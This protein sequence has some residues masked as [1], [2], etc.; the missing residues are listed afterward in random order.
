M[1]LFR[2]KIVGP[3]GTPAFSR[4]SRSVREREDQRGLPQSHECCASS[5]KSQVIVVGHRETIDPR[6][7]CGSLWLARNAINLR[8]GRTFAEAN[9]RGVTAAEQARF[10]VRPSGLVFISG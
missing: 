5:A 7:S 9:R 4:P 6:S 8:N 10:A 1:L 3:R 2:M